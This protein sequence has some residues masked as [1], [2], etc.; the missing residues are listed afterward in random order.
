MPDVEHIHNPFAFVDSI[1][2]S[3]DRGPPP[4]EQMTEFL[5]FGDGCP[6]VR[7][8]FEAVDGLGETI[9][10]REGL[11]GSIGFDSVVDGLHVA[12]GTAG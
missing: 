1:N 5:V 7:E 8:S 11:H 4:K 10:P 6:S 12:Q 9:K 3:V 2:N